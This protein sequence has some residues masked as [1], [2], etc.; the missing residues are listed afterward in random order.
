[1]PLALLQLV[2]RAEGTSRPARLELT[3]VVFAQFTESLERMPETGRTKG[4]A[5]QACRAK[6]GDESA[7]LT[8]DARMQL[9]SGMNL[10]VAL[11]WAISPLRT[12]LA[13]GRLSSHSCEPHFG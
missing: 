3:E 8:F 13:L 5:E 11:Y 1:M 10:C 7:P 6:E 2:N 12:A 9:I 4:V